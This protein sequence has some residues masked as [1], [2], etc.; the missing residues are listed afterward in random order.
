MLVWVFIGL[1]YLLYNAFLPYLQTIRGAKFGDGSAYITYRNSLI[2]SSLGIPGALIGAVLLEIP[3]LG[4]KGTLA[5]ST[6]VTYIFQYCSTTALTSSSLLGWN[7][8]FKPLQQC[9]ICGSL[10]VYTP[11]IFRTKDSGAGNAFIAISNG[12]LESW[13]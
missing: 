8:A 6:V 2:I 11:E 13:L 12:Y 3:E 5:G 10:R 9:D 7:Y 4:R 1:G